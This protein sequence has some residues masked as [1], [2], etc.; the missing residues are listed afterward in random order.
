VLN[1]DVKKKLLLE[2]TR[3]V[4]KQIQQKKLTETEDTAMQTIREEFGCD[5]LAMLREIEVFTSGT[6]SR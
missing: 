2:Y 1:P 3:L 4:L 5:H 6:V